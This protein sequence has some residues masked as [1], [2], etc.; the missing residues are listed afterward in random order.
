LE[1]FVFLCKFQTNQE[2]TKKIQKKLETSKLEKRRSKK[3]EAECL[4]SSQHVHRQKHVYGQ[5]EGSISDPCLNPKH[6]FP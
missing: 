6:F 1:I 5:L 4:M 3:P 2:K